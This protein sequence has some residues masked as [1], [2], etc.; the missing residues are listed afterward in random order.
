MQ[1]FPA[2]RKMRQS[3]SLLVILY[4]SH[5]N[6]TKTEVNQ[7]KKT[8]AATRKKYLGYDK[9]FLLNLVRAC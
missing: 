8:R 7:Q 4:A 9:E 6:G 5:G 2:Y 1:I 3:R